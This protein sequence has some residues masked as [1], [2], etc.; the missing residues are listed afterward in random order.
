[1]SDL[2][3]LIALNYLSERSQALLAGTPDVCFLLDSGA[4][5]AWKKGK[6]VQLNDY[7]RS[8]ETLKVKPWRYFALDKIGDPKGT[9][10]N[11][12][13]LNRRGF[14]PIPIFTR[15]ESPDRLDELYTLNDVVGIGGLV[16][17]PNNKGFVRGIMEKI[18]GRRCH[19][20]GF[21]S[22]DF[23]SA[24]K[25][26]SCD[27]SSWIAPMRFGGKFPLY[28]GQGRWITVTQKDFL[29]RPSHSLLAHFE[30]YDEDLTLLRF[31]E[32]WHNA[33]NSGNRSIGFRL[34]TKSWV[35]Y[36]MEVEKRL[37]TKLFLAAGCD[38]D[39]EA[40]VRAADF[41]RSK[42]KKA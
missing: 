33:S 16:G 38:R 30:E 11:L 1:M 41:W 24:Y 14:K 3:I 5:T 9:H 37:G 23:M 35:R 10:E 31:K 22:H 26:F 2:N 6:E 39:V 7:C 34:L 21:T 42:I 8:I 12:L 25:P 19:W 28:I 20:L 40:I 4:F 32:G 17:T 13:E 18:G 36:S 15:G 29:S 27:S